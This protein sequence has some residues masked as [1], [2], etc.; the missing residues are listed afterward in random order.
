MSVQGVVAGQAGWQ[1]RRVHRLPRSASAYAAVVALAALVAAALAVAADAPT[2]AEWLAFV[3][4]LPLAAAAPLFRV[5]VGRNHSLHAAPAFVVAGAL[6]LPPLLVVALVVALYL[7]LGIRDP[8]PWYIQTFNVA[9]LMLSGLTAWLVVEA[10]GQDSDLGFALSGL[11]AAGT[12]VVVNHVLLA[13]MLQLARGHSMRESGLFSVSGLGTEFVIAA[14]GL[15]VGA[16]AIVNPWLIPAVI[17]PLALAHRSLSTTSQLRETEERFRTMFESAPT[18]TFLFGIDGAV[19]IANRSALSLFGY[20][21]DEVG[22]MHKDSISHPDDSAESAQ[23][24]GELARGDRDEYRREARFVT[25][26]GRTVV[27]RFAVALVRDA[28]GKPDFAIA[29][30]EDVTDRKQLEEQLLQ[31]QKLEA[32]GRLAGGVAHDFNNMLTAIGGYTAFALE[33]ADDGSPLRSDL[34]EIRKATDRAAKLTRQLLAFSRKQ[35]LTPELLNLNGIVVE[36]QSMLKPLIG[37]DVI[38]TTRLDPALGPIEADPGQLHQVV[39]NLVVNARDAMPGGGN[40][41]IQTANVDVDEI[42]DGSIEPGRY[43]TLTVRDAGEG[44]DEE[45]LGQIFEPFFTTKEPGKG[46]GLGLATVYGIVKQSGGYLEVDSEIGVG[47]AFTIYLRRVDDARPHRPEP[48]PPAPIELARPPSQ[49]AKRVLVVEDEEV[50]RRL[51]RQVLEGEGYEV[52]VAQDGEAA[53]EIAGR[54]TIDL[55][56]TDL[57]MPNVGGRELAERLRAEQPGL[58]IVYMSGYVEDELSGALPPATS[59]LSKPFTFSELTEK[60]RD[61]MTAP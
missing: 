28:D 40:L 46:T 19:M 24:F 45:T 60:V 57:T 36:M 5:P 30:A 37:E 26:D 13:V 58:R 27:T 31:S 48:A 43:V 22:L 12:L 50:V 6:V 15:A 32:I 3:V 59:F 61:L 54:S 21:Q 10:I 42:G 49:E 11:A 14:L 47:S 8:Y 39:M 52:L 1:S 56:L 34:D 18:A 44:I 9:N 2:R 29:M 33:H 53:I 55:L 25:K 38:L 20:E 35:V 23:L 4:L 41:T 51:V 17:A 16:F 7:P